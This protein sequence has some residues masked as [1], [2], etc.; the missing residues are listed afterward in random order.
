[1]PGWA[2]DSSPKATPR[3]V[4]CSAAWSRFAVKGNSLGCIQTKFE[5]PNRGS[6]HYRV[7]LR[8]IMEHEDR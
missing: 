3:L 5:V 4:Y 1:M 7:F 2:R 8:P 6:A